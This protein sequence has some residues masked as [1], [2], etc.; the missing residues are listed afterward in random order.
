MY[1][2][3]NSTGNNTLLKIP[4]MY[5]GVHMC[6][7]G[8]KREGMLIGFLKAIW[9][10]EWVDPQSLSQVSNLNPLSSPHS[11]AQWKS[12]PCLSLAVF[13]C[14]HNNHLVLN[15]HT[16]LFL[17]SL[18]YSHI[19]LHVLALILSSIPLCSCLS[20]SLTHTHVHTRSFKWQK[21]PPNH[22]QYV[23]LVEVV[24]WSH[25]R[26][27][28]Y[29]WS[30]T[31]RC[32]LSCQFTQKL[33]MGKSCTIKA[34]LPLSD[35]SSFIALHPV[36][37]SFPDFPFSICDKINIININNNAAGSATSMICKARRLWEFQQ[38]L[39]NSLNP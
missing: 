30:I 2:C 37:N 29:L 21:Q 12:F 31:T 22:I 34:I 18:L 7:W 8:Q 25:N 38:G 5:D 10:S 20:P 4:C 1:E 24:H 26:K 35:F 27:D 9:S 39:L 33:L 11:R 28:L 36:S 13:S 14:C 32:V 3:V 19:H 23:V 15:L 16:L 17:L 6:A